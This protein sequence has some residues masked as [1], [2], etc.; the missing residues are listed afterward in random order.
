M[1]RAD[2]RVLNEQP[3]VRWVDRPVCGALPTL[4]RAFAVY[5]RL[6]AETCLIQMRCRRGVRLGSRAPLGAPD[7]H[8]GNRWT[9][10]SSLRF[11]RLRSAGRWTPYWVRPVRAG[12]A[13]DATLGP[14]AMSRTVATQ[15]E[16]SVTFSCRRFARFRI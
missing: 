16:R 9:C 11:H 3:L 4:R 14:K 5:R 2:A 10:T 7:V 8:S 15:P 6:P 13:G 12:P 1:E